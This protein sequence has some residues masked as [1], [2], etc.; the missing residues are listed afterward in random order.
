MSSVVAW[1]NLP[2]GGPLDTQTTT[3]DFPLFIPKYGCGVK[4]HSGEISYKIF[5]SKH[6]L[7]R[8]KVSQNSPKS[9]SKGSLV[10]YGLTGQC[11]GGILLQN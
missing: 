11:Q 4:V 10:L 5:C 8:N 6:T 3:A 7:A 9:A 1:K 2:T